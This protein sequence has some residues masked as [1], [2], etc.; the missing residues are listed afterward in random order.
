MLV[1]MKGAR[2]GE[3]LSDPDDQVRKEMSVEWQRYLMGKEE[4]PAL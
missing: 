2:K 3:F 4:R 1:S